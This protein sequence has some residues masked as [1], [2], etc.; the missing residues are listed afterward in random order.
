MYF[1]KYHFS[2]ILND[3]VDH[4]I[5]I[6]RSFFKKLSPPNHKFRIFTIRSQV[7]THEFKLYLLIR[8]AWYF[9]CADQEKKTFQ[10]ERVLSFQNFLQLRTYKFTKDFY[11]RGFINFILLNLKILNFIQYTSTTKLFFFYKK[12]SINQIALKCLIKSAK[13]LTKLVQFEF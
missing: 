9:F 4:F 10:I 12:N 2:Q 1:N 11:T 5:N 3:L 7:Y 13:L 6:S 8:R